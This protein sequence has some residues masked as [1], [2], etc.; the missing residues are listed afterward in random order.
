MA[1]RD[2]RAAVEQW[3]RDNPTKRVNRAALGGQFEG[4]PKRRPTTS[5]TLKR[6]LPTGRELM[7]MIQEGQTKAAPAE[8]VETV[9]QR[10]TESCEELIEMGARIRP[11]M[12]G[13]KQVGWIRGVH[14]SERK[15]LKRW[16]KDPDDFIQNMLLLATSYTLEE[17]EIMTSPEVYGLMEL[18]RK[19]SEYDMSLFPYLSAFSSTQQSE[20]LWFSKGTKLTNFENRII[21]MPDGKKIRIA[22]PPDHVRLWASLCTYREQAKKRLDE[23]WNALL[24]VRPMA[25]KSANPITVE[26]K[27]IARSLETGSV[28]PWSRIVKNKIDYRDGWGHPGDTVEDLKREM[29][30]MIRGDKHEMVMDAWGKQ[31][32]SD[33]QDRLKKIDD[34]R[35]SRNTTGQAGVVDERIEYFTETEMRERQAALRQGKV[36]PA[37]E[38]HEERERR[39][40]VETNVS[41][42]RRY[43]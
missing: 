8:Y 2:N 13:N 19:M 15:Q 27:S 9:R 37:K 14:A 22:C 26:L 30:A 25:G 20:N 18:V 35:K 24:I 10:V 29:D 40:S 17:V 36:P 21:E 32:E 12:D 28:E 42:L 1:D 3:Q 11:L 39:E 38:R 6:A 5:P 4:D 33:E 16:L 41:K 43:R 34:L 31:M 7:D 23:N